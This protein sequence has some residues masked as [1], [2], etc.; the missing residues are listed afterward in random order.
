M[1]QTL[2]KIGRYIIFLIYSWSTACGLY[3]IENYGKENTITYDVIK[4]MLLLTLILFFTIL[5][6]SSVTIFKQKD[7]A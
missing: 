4:N 1:N 5:Y 3:V 6:F 7:K 2:L